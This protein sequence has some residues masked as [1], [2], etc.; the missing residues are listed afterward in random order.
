MDKGIEKHNCTRPTDVRKAHGKPGD[1]PTWSSGAKTLVGTAA[2]NRSRIWFTISNGNLNEIY[3]PDVDQA[4]TRSV[5]FLVT[6]GKTFFSDGQWDAEHTVTWLAPGVPGCHIKSRCKQARYTITKD[7]I[8]DPAR[9]TLMM[10]VNFKTSE[11]NL[12]LY[13]F[14]EPQMG[15]QG[16]D[17]T[18][19]VGSYKSVTMLLAQRD[20]K[21][22]N[23]SERLE[24]LTVTHDGIDEMMSVAGNIRRIASALDIFTLIRNKA[25]ASKDSVLSTS[26][27]GYFN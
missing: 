9:D 7:I 19:W 17:N 16:A 12:K 21:L 23:V 27:N 4:N 2:S 15:D 10:R 1:E 20:R 11:Q 24:T 6:D 3:F 5:R 13:L 14:A 22:R 25:G 18:A 8:T 26:T